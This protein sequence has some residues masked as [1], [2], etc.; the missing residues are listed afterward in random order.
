MENKNN[1][2]YF[3]LI[4]CVTQA[5]GRTQSRPHDHMVIQHYP[6]NIVVHRNL[7]PTPIPIF[8]RC[9][10]INQLN[11]AYRTVNM[12]FGLEHYNY[13]SHNLDEYNPTI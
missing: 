6:R 13:D 1:S 7:R 4:H 9:E 5:I 10:N 2:L 3:V 11:M 12:R 8:K